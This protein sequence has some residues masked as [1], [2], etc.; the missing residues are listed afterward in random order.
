MGIEDY[1]MEEPTYESD[2][3]ISSDLVDPT[4][5]ET[6][7]PGDYSDPTLTD[8]SAYASTPQELPAEG[9]PYAVADLYGPSDPTDIPER[10]TSLGQ[11]I[12][13]AL[14]AAVP[15][16]MGATS[17]KAGALGYGGEGALSA[18]KTAVDLISKQNERLGKQDLYKLQTQQRKDAQLAIEKIRQ[19]NQNKRTAAVVSGADRR[20]KAFA[21]AK[22]DAEAEKA[23]DKAD[24]RAER[25]A[26]AQLDSQA[27]FNQNLQAENQYRREFGKT[28]EERK[29][30]TLD[31]FK[32]QLG[33][34]DKLPSSAALKNVAT[35]QNAMSVTGRDRAK[36]NT[37][38]AQGDLFRSNGI[39]NAGA[40]SL[41]E[42]TPSDQVPSFV[43]EEKTTIQ[44]QIAANATAISRAATLADLLDPKK[45]G[46][47]V[48]S[49]ISFP[50]D[51]RT[52]D[53]RIISKKEVAQVMTERLQTLK[54]LVL[55]VKEANNMGANFTEPEMQIVSDMIGARV[56]SGVT[57]WDDLTK[58]FDSG[59]IRLVNFQKAAEN[60]KNFLAEK[61]L[62]Q[63]ESRRANI[64]PEVFSRMQP[65]FYG[66]LYRTPAGFQRL[67]EYN[68]RVMQSP[69]MKRRRQEAL[70]NY[71]NEIV[72]TEE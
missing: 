47:G 13:T 29:P 49:D 30:I 45:G 68:K 33:I 69:F 11:T 65:E 44:K 15:L 46:R 48:P 10:K 1:L 20:A 34:T 7:Q 22:A 16:I 26:A 19:E 67:R 51:L 58:L 56:P 36:Y 39:Y 62:N 5:Y 38:I 2:H 18:T 24:A 12:A 71:S 64:D 21:Q 63:L 37:K 6:A 3:T 59:R 8:L 66:F 53:G 50:Q 27:Q 40:L 23:Q 25:E 72:G 60:Y 55:E 54:E 61:M 52:T 4:L 41:S 17:K 43:G 57:K 32:A 31:E 35:T 9:D 70:Q 14:A 28:P 42:D